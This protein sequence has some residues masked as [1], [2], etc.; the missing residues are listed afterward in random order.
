MAHWQMPLHLPKAGLHQEAFKAGV[1]A[2]FCWRSSCRLGNGERGRESKTVKP[3]THQ[4]ILPVASVAL[5]CGWPVTPP[6]FAQ[7]YPTKPIRIV[8]AFPPGGSTDF[9]AR[10]L[11]SHLPKALGQS[12]VVDNRGGAGGNI[13]NDIV[14]KAAPDGY[15][16]LVTTEGA[17]TISPS[18]YASLPYNATRDL[19][20]ITQ[21]IKYA[22]VV[23][24]HP[25]VKAGTAK[26]LVA[27]AKDQPGKLSYAHPGVGTNVHLGAE[28]FNQMAGI[29][30]TGVSYK[31]GGPAIISLI[32]NETQIS[33]ATPPSAIPHVKSGRLKVIAVTSAKRSAALPDLPTLAESGVA[34]YNVEG[35][36]GFYAPAKTP[37]SIIARVYD[38]TTKVLKLPE[39]R[40]AVLAT[41]SEPS[42][43]SPRETT[44]IVR[45]E[46]AMWAK[47]IKTVGVKIE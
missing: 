32:G 29:K 36:V 25:S 2:G 31:G 40:D 8:V 38:E 7:T 24:L 5:F 30:I 15:T 19:A 47:L 20:P 6:A 18:L 26:E 14:A 39:V 46:T 10:V 37:D 45:E 4:C 16:L 27:L 17:I 22:N 44:T 11:A 3:V 41:G 42:G 34:G 13:G 1:N 9:A 12:I 35:W 21:I 23:A 33:F 43:I 28:L